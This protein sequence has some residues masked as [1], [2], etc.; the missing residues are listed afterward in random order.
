MKR[1]QI[2]IEEE[3]DVALE[4]QALEEGTSKAALIRQ[5]VRQNLKFLG[6]LKADPLWQM[7]GADD[8]DPGGTS[9]IDDIVYS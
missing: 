4:R 2:M 5:C 6:P 1:L 7:V 9:E 3:L 8:F